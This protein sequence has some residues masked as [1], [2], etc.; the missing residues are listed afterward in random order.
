MTT[1]EFL[2]KLTAL[3]ACAPAKEWVATQPDAQT[4]WDTCDERPWVDWYF[5]RTATDQQTLE[6]AKV[7]NETSAK[8]RETIRNAEAEAA[9]VSQAAWNKHNAFLCNTTVAGY[10]K[11]SFPLSE[12]HKASDAAWDNY[13]VVR[14]VAYKDQTQTRLDAIRRIMPSP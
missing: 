7:Y 5:Y 9:K 4:A 14:E 8:C 13:E 11:E 6:Y 12:Y 3:D 10:E 1:S 2:Q